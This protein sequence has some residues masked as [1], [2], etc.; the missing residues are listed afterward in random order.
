LGP[1][2][3]AAKTLKT[4]ENKDKKK[5]KKIKTAFFK[6]SGQKLAPARPFFAKII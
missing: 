1:W 4:R 2:P 5:A 6:A 3:P